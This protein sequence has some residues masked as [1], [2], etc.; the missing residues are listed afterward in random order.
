MGMTVFWTAASSL[1]L[2]VM[3]RLAE[4]VC[5]LPPQMREEA[6][7]LPLMLALTTFYGVLAAKLPVLESCFPAT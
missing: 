6:Q 5:L 7:T 2:A 3:G 1:Y 4:E